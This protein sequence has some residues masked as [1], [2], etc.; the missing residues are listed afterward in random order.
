MISKK[1]PEGG[2]L[3]CACHRDGAG[4]YAEA[5]QEA[6]P[7]LTSLITAHERTPAAREPGS[8]AKA[9][10]HVGRW[11]TVLCARSNLLELYSRENNASEEIRKWQVKN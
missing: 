7:L 4:A 2:F 5:P 9:G 3:L 8:V 10:H 11:Y 1:P 6:E